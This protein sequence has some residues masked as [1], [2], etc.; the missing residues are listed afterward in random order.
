MRWQP[1]HIVLAGRLAG[2][3]II[4]AGIGL[5]AWDVSDFYDQAG[6]SFPTSFKVRDFLDGSLHWLDVGL[7]VL[8]AQRSSIK[9]G[10][11]WGRTEAPAPSWTSSPSAASSAPS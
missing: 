8:V 11:A 9:S 4:F 3:A 10:S 5:S 2:F 7:L 6:L 1:R